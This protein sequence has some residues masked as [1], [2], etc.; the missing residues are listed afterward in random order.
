MTNWRAVYVGV[1]LTTLATL[2][3]ELSLTRIFSVVFYYHFAFLAISI[4]LFGLGLGGLLSYGVRAERSRLWARLAMLACGGSLFTAAALIWLLT[5]GEPS[6]TDLALVYFL[7]ALPFLCAGAQVSLVISHAVERVDRVYFADLLGAAAGCLLLVPLLDFAGGPNTVLA[8]ATIFA[9]AAWW[10]SRVARQRGLLRTATGLLV[11]L[12]ALLV[13]NRE[14]RWLDV[15]HAKGRDL[16]AKQ[17]RFVRWNSFSRVALAG[18]VG[19]AM[20]YI[21]ADASTGVPYF[22][23][24]RLTEADRRQ[25]LQL[26]P[27]LPY[28]LRP[29]AKTLV[30]GAGGGWDVARALA[31]GSRDVTAVEINPIIAETI[32]RGRFRDLSRGLYQRPEVHVIVEDARSFIRRSRDR[33]QVIQATLVDTWAATAAGA[34]ALS[35]NNLY[36]VEAFREYLERL[37]PD[38]VLAFSRWGLEPPRESLRVVSLAAAALERLGENE[39]WR[40][41]VVAREG[42]EAELAGWGLLDHILIARRPL[43]A[44]DLMRLHREITGHGL[45]LAYAPDAQL[46]GPFTELLRS[47]DR[48]AFFRRYPFDVRPVTDDRPFFFYTVQPREVWRFLERVGSRSADYQV[49]RAVPVLFTLLTV[50]LVAVALI[51][52]VP[53]LLLRSRLPREAGLWPLLSYFLSIGV[54]YILVQVALVQKFLLLLGRPTYALTVIVFSMLVSSSL[55]SYFSARL[56]RGSEPRLRLVAAAVAGAILILAAGIG[57]L[58]AA[59]VGWPTA[60]K[61]VLTVLWVAPAGFLMGMLFPSGLRLLDARCSA[62]VRWAWSLNAAASVLGS[63]VAVALAI[64]AGLRMTLV[65]GAAMYAAAWTALRLGAGRKAKASLVRAS[66][67]VAG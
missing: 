36:T 25:A 8:S 5:R 15:W 12:L 27:S 42:T 44:E 24:D 26:G 17:E 54:G 1:A 23:F 13:A 49:N 18:D 43:S 55:G 21:D 64:Y 63:V 16:R 45:K 34:F 65:T 19:S 28:W 40:H 9:A 11:V 2:L 57:P 37:T 48:S 38:G 50:S 59:A 58:L 60:V 7:T 67:A 30:I 52:L 3:L 51:L 14:G 33:Y 66:Q 39:A 31:S 56:L 4:A 6:A 41:V 35:E 46:P 29:G 20:I 32:M 53:R 62:A 61:I 10:W 47:A 22:D